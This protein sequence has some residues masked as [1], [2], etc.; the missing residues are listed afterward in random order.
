VRL[1][2]II[3]SI[4]LLVLFEHT[5][6][7]AVTTITQNNLIGSWTG[8]IPA[9]VGEQDTLEI[10]SEGSSSF[11]R[12]F[13]DGTVETLNADSSH[14]T[15]LQDITIVEFDNEAGAKYKM[16]LSGWSTS[17]SKKIFGTLYLYNNG[18]LFNGMGIEFIPKN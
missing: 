17:N 9:D 11:S 5:P 16:V 3:V 7:L 13:S 6:C 2:V 12:K 18:H 1:A 14:T 4:G 15:H 10:K 8:K